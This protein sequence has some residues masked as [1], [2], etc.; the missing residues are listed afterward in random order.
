M[1]HFSP[2]TNHEQP[3]HTLY[4]EV[5]REPAFEGWF[6]GFARGWPLLQPQAYREL[7][8]AAGFQHTVVEL[9][10]Y[11]HSLPSPAAIADFTRSTTARPFLAR[12]ADADARDAYLA[13]YARRV[14]EC[15]PPCDEAGTTLFDFHR[16]L[17]VGQRPRE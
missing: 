16:L 9:R 17:M 11:R 1:T 6:R 12:I 15:H 3:S 5:A 14:A 8:D 13:R 2:K 4:E 10:T 7:L